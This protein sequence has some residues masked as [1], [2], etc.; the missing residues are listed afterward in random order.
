MFANSNDLSSEIKNKRLIFSSEK[1]GRTI[2]LREGG[3]KE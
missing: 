1:I 3:I 2:K